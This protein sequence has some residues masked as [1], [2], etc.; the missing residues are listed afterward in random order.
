M[1]HLLH[2]TTEE[3]HHSVGQL[4]EGGSRVEVEHGILR[5]WDRERRLLARV[6]RRKNK[7]YVLRLQ[8]A[9]LVALLTQH[10][11]DAWW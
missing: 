8:V 10:E 9:R 4:D 5:I 7:L 6:E 2:P 11:E 1:G 3:F